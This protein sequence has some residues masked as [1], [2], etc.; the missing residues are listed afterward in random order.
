MIFFKWLVNSFINITKLSTSSTGALLLEG[1]KKENN[2]PDFLDFGLLDFVLSE[3]R[4]DW[5][6]VAVSSLVARFLFS[7]VIESSLSF[8]L[9]KRIIYF[10]FKP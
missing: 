2:P 4:E 6:L 10:R 5:L 3:P 9:T 1:L 7:A 8:S